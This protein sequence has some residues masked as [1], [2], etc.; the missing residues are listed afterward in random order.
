VDLAIDLLKRLR[1]KGITEE[2]LA[3]AKAYLKGTYP[4]QQIETAD[5]LAEILA[6]I[7]L[8]DLN[9]GEVDDLFSRIDSVTLERA[10]EVARKYYNSDNLTF[11][12]LGNAAKFAGDL[13]KYSDTIVK[14]SIMAPGVTLTR[15]SP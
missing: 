12:L 5:Q 14:G 10:N 9:R 7:E 6:E 1:E 11:V 3:S 8:Y 2:Q 4:S 13:Q 15:P